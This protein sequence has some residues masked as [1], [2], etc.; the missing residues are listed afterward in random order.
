MEEVIKSNANNIE[1]MFDKMQ[2]T[3]VGG[4]G[5]EQEEP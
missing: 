1:S 3:V 4:R 2:I 5:E